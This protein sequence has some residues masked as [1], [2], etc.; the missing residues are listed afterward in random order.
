LSNLSQVVLQLTQNTIKQVVALTG[1][2][3]TGPQCSHRVIIRLEVAWRH[4]LAC[5]GAAACRP[6]VVLQTTDVRDRF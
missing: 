1:R 5:A 2:Y 4:H 3:T 6:T